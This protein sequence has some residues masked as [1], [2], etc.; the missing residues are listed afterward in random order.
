MEL[1]AEEVVAEMVEVM[2][3]KVKMKKVRRRRKKK[4]R[5]WW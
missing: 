5:R 4:Q 1:A 2:R 3:V